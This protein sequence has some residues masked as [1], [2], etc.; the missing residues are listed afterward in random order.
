MKS[1][2]FFSI[3]CFVLLSSCENF[4][5]KDVEIEVDKF[6]PG[7]AMT[8]LWSND[9]N[10][11]TIL[12]SEAV[13]ILEKSPEPV[14]SSKLEVI[15]NNQLLGNFKLGKGPWKTPEFRLVAGDAVSLK[16]NIQDK[17]F[18]ESTQTMPDSIEILSVKFTRDSLLK[19]FEQS[20]YDFFKI[21]IKDLATAH[22]YYKVNAYYVY[23]LDEDSTNIQYESR[24]M[25]AVDLSRTDGEIIKDDFFNG[26]E[27]ELV[28]RTYSYDPGYK[29]IGI[30]LDCHNLSKDY[31]LFESS[32]TRSSY[33]NGNPFAEPTTIHQNVKNGY[34]IFGLSNKTR[35]LIRI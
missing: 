12:V 1:I 16:L 10:G 4:F 11:N 33:S 29:L 25:E 27:Y 22:N 21:K 14:D 17:V 13:G 18:L 24:F 15:I 20:E 34:G 31:Y 6:P 35:Y 23:D 19:G 26:K 7:Y 8:A 9:E 3:G 30:L 2:Y 28:F 32:K 5:Y